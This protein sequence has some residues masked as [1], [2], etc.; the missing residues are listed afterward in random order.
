MVVV[1]QTASEKEQ[2]EQRKLGEDGF[3]EQ[4][5]A[6]AQ[7]RATRFKGKRL[8]IG[9]VD[10]VAIQ[11]DGTLRYLRRE[12][13]DQDHQ[14]RHARISVGDYKILHVKLYDY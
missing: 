6:A 10:E 3:A 14:G 2:T 5:Q 9:Y 13:G 4:G 7:V 12:N 1:F 11:P 8:G